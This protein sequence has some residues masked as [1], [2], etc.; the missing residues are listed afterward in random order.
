[1]LLDLFIFYYEAVVMKIKTVMANRIRNYK[2]TLD[3]KNH[4]SLRTN[5]IY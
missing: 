4:R 3:H 5:L 2:K 1:M